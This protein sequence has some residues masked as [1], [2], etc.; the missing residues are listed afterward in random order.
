MR[1]SPGLI[2][3]RLVDGTVVCLVCAGRRA[4]AGRINWSSPAEA[5]PVCADCKKPILA[6]RAEWPEF[7]ESGEKS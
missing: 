1:F 6:E 4:C 7:C 2:P 5:R 3:I